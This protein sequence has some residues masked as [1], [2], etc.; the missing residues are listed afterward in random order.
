MQHAKDGATRPRARRAGLHPHDVIA[1]HYRR[2]VSAADPSNEPPRAAPR[3]RTSLAPCGG[4]RCREAVITFLMFPL[5]VLLAFYA[6]KWKDDGWRRKHPFL[7]HIASPAQ[8][9]SELPS[10]FLLDVKNPDGSPLSPRELVHMVKQ[11]KCATGQRTAGMRRAAATARTSHPGGARAQLGPRAGCGRRSHFEGMSD[12][13]AAKLIHDQM[14]ARQPKSR[15]YYRVAATRLMTA[16]P[17]TVGRLKH[18][19]RGSMAKMADVMRRL[20]T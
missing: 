19:M 20:P 6:D 14:V 7:K 4:L 13:Q 5:L 15:A 17:T 2:V 16:T 12:E 8:D 11:L 1:R 10:A 3:I 9:K 18:D